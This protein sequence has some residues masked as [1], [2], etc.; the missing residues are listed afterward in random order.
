[1]AKIKSEL[2]AEKAQTDNERF[3]RREKISQV[4]LY[5]QRVELK[6]QYGRN[7]HP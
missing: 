1:M 5:H 4:F 2:I 6:I 3:G 7:Q